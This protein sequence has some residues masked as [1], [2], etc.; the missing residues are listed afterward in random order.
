MDITLIIELI[1]CN[2]KTRGAELVTLVFV[3]RLFFSAFLLIIVVAFAAV[4]VV[5]TC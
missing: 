3:A 2:T 4:V 1:H 5:H